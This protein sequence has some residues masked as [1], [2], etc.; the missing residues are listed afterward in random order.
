MRRAEGLHLDPADVQYLAALLVSMRQRLARYG[1]TTSAQATTFM[2]QVCSAAARFEEQNRSVNGTPSGV[3]T[4]DGPALSH[5]LIG[6][7]EAAAILG[8]GT[9]GVRQLGRRGTLTG[10]R[11]GGRWLFAAADV[12]RRAE[13]RAG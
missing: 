10:Y 5:D 4:S 8:I 2:D 13:R 11:A 3:E 6:T 9:A 12:V 1:V 7:A